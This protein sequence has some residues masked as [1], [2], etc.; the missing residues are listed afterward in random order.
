[1]LVGRQATNKQSFAIG[2]KGMY[3]SFITLERRSHELK[4]QRR[5]PAMTENVRL[6]SEMS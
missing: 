3:I 1:M 5:Y 4:S 2:L 6:W